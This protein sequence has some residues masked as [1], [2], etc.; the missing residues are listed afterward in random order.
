MRD[1]APQVCFWKQPYIIYKI[2]SIFVTY[3]KSDTI[4]RRATYA[5]AAHI[6]SGFL[7]FCF[8]FQ[9]EGQVFFYFFS[10]I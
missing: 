9:R 3:L 6:H 1:M 10:L 4:C 5:H 2:A 7:H 8:F